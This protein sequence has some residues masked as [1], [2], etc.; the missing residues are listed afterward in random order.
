[1]LVCWY[2]MYYVGSEYIYFL[3]AFCPAV[4]PV[5]RSETQHY[6]APMDSTVTLQ[7]QTEGSPPPLITW[8]KDGQLLSDSVRHRLLSSGSLQ[9]AFV[10]PSDAGR[11]TCIAANAAG[12]ISLNMGLTVHS[13]FYLAQ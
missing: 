10:Q 3:F 12:T 6:V 1:M 13:R 2:G 9:L 4:P 8:H 7:C 11:Y 5:I